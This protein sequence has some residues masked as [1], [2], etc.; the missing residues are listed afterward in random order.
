M[1]DITDVKWFYS[2]DSSDLSCAMPSSA[3]VVVGHQIKQTGLQPGK[4]GKVANA[5]IIQ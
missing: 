4:E 2:V 3:L 1:T 5:A